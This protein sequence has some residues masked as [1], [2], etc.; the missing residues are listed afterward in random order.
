MFSKIVTT[1]Q[2]KITEQSKLTGLLDNLHHIF[3]N[4]R[5]TV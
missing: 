2:K 1:L 3:K 4:I 5:E